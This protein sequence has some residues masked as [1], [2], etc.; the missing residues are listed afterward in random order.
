MLGN[1]PE[2][3]L[4]ILLESYGNK[5]VLR[6]LLLLALQCRSLAVIYERGFSSPVRAP[7]RTRKGRNKIS[8]RINRIS[9]ICALKLFQR[10]SV[11][12]NVTHYRVDNNL[13]I[14]V[15]IHIYH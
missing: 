8:F 5:G 11:N 14:W 13:C 6:Q 3:V 9:N 4:N 7:W 15:I 2:S 10:F 1:S 12:Y